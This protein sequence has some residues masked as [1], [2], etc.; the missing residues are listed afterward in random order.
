LAIDDC[1]FSYIAKLKRTKRKKKCHCG[2]G[3]FAAMAAP[4]N[5][6]LE[7]GKG[8]WGSNQL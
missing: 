3:P 6:S 1:H 2:T 5:I 8:I 7:K 4:R